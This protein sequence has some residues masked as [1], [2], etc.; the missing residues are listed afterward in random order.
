M[1]PGLRQ[2][3]Q[4]SLS[5][6]LTNA[7]SWFYAAAEKVIAERKLHPVSQKKLD[8]IIRLQHFSILSS[9]PLFNSTIITCSP[10]G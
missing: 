7:L 6:M 9:I 8:L 2:M 5:K 10:T 4:R 3:A 1:T